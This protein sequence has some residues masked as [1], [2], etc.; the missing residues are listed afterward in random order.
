[1]VTRK[2]GIG[3]VDITDYR[4][5]LTKERFQ[6]DKTSIWLADSASITLKT[7]LSGMKLF[8]KCMLNVFIYQ[9]NVS[10]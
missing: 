9:K 8:N 3:N 10:W 7:L 4:D 5:V 1:M 2:V 6:I